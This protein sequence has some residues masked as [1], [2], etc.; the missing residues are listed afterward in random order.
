MVE[1]FRRSQSTNKLDYCKVFVNGDWIGFTDKPQSI[2]NELKEGRKNGI[3]NI[4]SSIYWDQQKYLLNIYTDAGRP[5]R[6]LLIVNDDNI[7]FNETIN[8]KIKLNKCNWYN[9]IS[10]IKGSDNYCIQ[11]IDPYETNNC[12]IAMNI[13]EVKSTGKPNVSYNSKAFSPE[14]VFFL[15]ELIIW[16]KSTNP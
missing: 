2:I 8:E 4:H 12:I 16:S 11:Y 14:I 13:N 15:L 7:I 3:I 10:S 1:I 5:I 9:L 6:P